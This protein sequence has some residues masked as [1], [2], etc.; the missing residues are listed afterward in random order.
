MEDLKQ[1]VE[2]FIDYTKTW[3]ISEDEWY[4]NMDCVRKNKGGKRY[5]TYE[6]F[7]RAIREDILYDFVYNI[8]GIKKQLEN[9]LECGYDSKIFD[10][11]SIDIENKIQKLFKD[12]KIERG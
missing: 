5:I 9:D 7:K 11:A 10:K 2:D 3:S 12:F 8:E 6:E 1:L 4:W